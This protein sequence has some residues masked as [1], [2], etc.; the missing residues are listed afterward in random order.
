M[1]L[2]NHPTGGLFKDTKA[3]VRSTILPEHQQ[4]FGFG[5]ESEDPHRFGLFVG[6]IPCLIPYLSHQQ[7]ITMASI[8]FNHLGDL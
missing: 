8:P 2:I 5:V 4:V 6:V 1:T 3:S 7:L